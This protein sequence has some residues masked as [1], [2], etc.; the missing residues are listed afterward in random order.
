MTNFTLNFFV[1]YKAILVVFVLG[2][3]FCFGFNDPNILK[4]V[5]ESLLTTLKTNKQAEYIVLLKDRLV[6]NK[7]LPFSNKM[8]KGNFVYQSLLRHAERTQKNIIKLLEDHHI[9][10]HSFFV[11][12]AIKVKSDINLLLKL[13]Q[14]SEIEKIVDDAPIYMLDYEQEKSQSRRNG[15]PEWGIKYIKADSVWAMGFTGQGVVIAGQDTGYDWEVSPIKSKYRGFIDST[16]VDHNYN[17]FDAIVKNN[18][19]FPDTILNPCGLATKFPCDDNNHGTHTMGTMVGQDDENTIGVAPGAKWMACRN[20][21][22]GWGQ[23]STYIN[24]FEWF[25]A[26]RDLDGKNPDPTKAPHVINN[27]WYCSLEE[28]CNLSNFVLMDDVVKNVKA[29]GIVVVVSAGNSGSSCGSV[30]G[31]PAIFEASF[32]V[33]ASDIN[34]N[35]AGFSSRGP[36]MIDSSFRLKP[37][38]SAPGVNVR[39]V[40]RG[41]D[42]ANFSGTSMA[43]PHMAGLVAL[44]ISANPKLAGN[45]EA[46][47][48]ILEIT[49]NATMSDQSCGDF[50][51]SKV[52]NAI[53]GYGIANAYEAVQRALAFNTGIENNEPSKI[54]VFPNPTHDLISFNLSKGNQS[55]KA[56]K[57]FDMQGQKVLEKYESDGHLLTTIPI[58]Q[59]TTGT[60]TFVLQASGQ[61]YYGKF[62]K[63]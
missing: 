43:G 46:I 4:K 3:Q 19:R 27:S 15:D 10:Y 51:G 21:D 11:T 53:F 28:G 45:V 39:S 26:P 48:D 63:L 9:Q 18:P 49:A 23:P 59:L 50:D 13:A 1:M 61:I 35:I 16:H 58:S 36:V 22:R 17:W 55:I 30:T 14:M 37:N 5:D 42:F 52:P 25:I 34:G 60:Y 56:I 12:N 54:L 7:H 57:I 24:C 44:I 62:V 32:S 31:P 29:A 38:A 8:D 33:G 20:M 40:I 47:E 41:G 6:F 2:I